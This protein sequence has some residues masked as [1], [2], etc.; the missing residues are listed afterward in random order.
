[1]GTQRPKSREPLTAAGAGSFAIAVHA[2]SQLWLS[3]VS[4]IYL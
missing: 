1:M 3:Y 2:T 4:P